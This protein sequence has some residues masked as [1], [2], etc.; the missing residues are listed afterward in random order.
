[1]TADKRGS[2]TDSLIHFCPFYYAGC[3]GKSIICQLSLWHYSS[4]L[5]F[6]THLRSFSYHLRVLAN[7]FTWKFA[8]GQL[9][10]RHVDITRQ[11]L[12]VK[13]L[14]FSTSVQWH[15]LSVQEYTQEESWYI[16]YGNHHFRFHFFSLS[17]IQET[18]K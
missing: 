14:S 2:R 6:S 11:D 18:K 17:Y 4:F 9:N 5:L 15:V 16:L 8:F 12:K 10:C 3:P 13:I 1:M 7:S